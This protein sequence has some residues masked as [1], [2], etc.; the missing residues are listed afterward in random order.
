MQ[1]IF[2]VIVIGLGAM[3]S[4]ALHHLSKNNL[5]VLGIDTFTP[6]HDQGSSAGESRIIREAYFEHPLYVPLIQRAYKLWY[7]L[8]DI[9]QES[10]IIE[11]GGLMLGAEDSSTVSGAETSAITHHLA[12]KK[13]NS[14][15]INQSYNCFKADEL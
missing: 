7:E 2:D 9:S 6:P 14:A 3:G 10:L 15:Q 1:D 4:S 5:N 11:T 12:Y 8:Q 13:L